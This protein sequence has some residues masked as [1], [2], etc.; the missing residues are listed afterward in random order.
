MANL[1][2]IALNNTID[3]FGTFLSSIG[4]YRQPES[5]AIGSSSH[6]KRIRRASSDLLLVVQINESKIA[7]HNEKLIGR[8]GLLKCSSQSESP[9]L[10]KTLC[11]ISKQ[12]QMLELSRHIQDIAKV[13]KRMCFP[14][15]LE[16]AEC[17]SVLA[18]NRFQYEKVL[19][20]F[21]FGEMIAKGGFGK[22]CDLLPA[23][24]DKHVLHTHDFQKGLVGKLSDP[25]EYQN[26]RKRFEQSFAA[27]NEIALIFRI[28]KAYST[29]SGY[30][31]MG[32]KF[33]PTYRFIATHEEEGVLKSCLIVMDH[34]GM[35]LFYKLKEG[36]KYPFTMHQ[37]SLLS[38]RM[39]YA[40]SFLHENNIIHR[41]FKCENVFEQGHLADFGN[42][43]AIESNAKIFGMVGTSRIMSPSMILDASYGKETDIWSLGCT[44]FEVYTEVPIFP[45]LESYSRCINFDS[46]RINHLMMIGERTARAPEEFLTGA[47]EKVLRRLCIRGNTGTYKLKKTRDREKLKSIHEVMHEIGSK[48]GDQ[49]LLIKQLTDIVLK[50]LHPIPR[51]RPSTKELIKGP[52]FQQLLSKKNI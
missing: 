44:I 3:T 22:V 28:Q 38:L 10:S 21:S 14:V 46:Q 31:E 2:C 19:S 45:D 25:Y 6:A 42:A 27:R 41:D 24:F 49:P 17:F 18:A 12:K 9:N 50:C 39:I 36:D 32:K 15:T 20:Y 29:Y 16:S 40:L 35:D 8:S 48:R 5:K 26:K 11:T 13:L 23:D 33:L 34:L 4:I 30:A 37:F 1:F 52:Y 7:I 47:S 51:K 43:V